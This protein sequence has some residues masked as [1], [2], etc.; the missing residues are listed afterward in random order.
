M[1]NGSKCQKLKDINYVLLHVQFCFFYVATRKLLLVGCTSAFSV[2]LL[3]SLIGGFIINGYY[4]H[5]Y[6][7]SATLVFVATGN[8]D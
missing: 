7:P 1:C 8:T 6:Y 2:N 3:H 5:Y 4:N